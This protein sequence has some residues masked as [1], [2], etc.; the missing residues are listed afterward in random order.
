MLV[1]N[2]DDYLLCLA[3][4]DEGRVFQDDEYNVPDFDEFGLEATIRAAINNSLDRAIT[5]YKK[6][7]NSI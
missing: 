5:K 2:A 1:T 3:E 4:Y 7:A 6:F